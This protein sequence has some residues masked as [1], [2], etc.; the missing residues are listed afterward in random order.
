MKNINRENLIKI[1]L[2]RNALNKIDI[3]KRPFYESGYSYNMEMARKLTL[4]DTIKKIDNNNTI[5][6]DFII[7]NKLLFTIY[8]LSELYKD[9]R[10]VKKIF[11][12]LIETGLKSLKKENLLD[13]NYDINIILDNLNSLNEI[14]EEFTILKKAFSYYLSELTL[15]IGGSPSYNNGYSYLNP[16]LSGSNL[17]KKNYNF[18]E[19]FTIFNYSQIKEILDYINNSELT[20]HDFAENIVKITKHNKNEVFYN[21]YFE[22]LKRILKYNKE[23]FLKLVRFSN[24]ARVRNS[25]T[26]K[27]ALDIANEIIAARSGIINSKIIEP[28]MFSKFPREDYF[29]FNKELE[30]INTIGSRT[31]CCFRKGGAAQSLLKPAYYSPISGIIEGTFKNCTWFSFVWETVEYNKETNLFDV[32]LVFDNLEATRR[33]TLEEMNKIIDILKSLGKYKKIYLG[34]LRNDIAD[35]YLESIES[36]KK[37]KERSLVEFEKEFNKYSAY[38]DSR[39]MF[40]ILENESK[41]KTNITVKKLNLGDLHRAKYVEWKIWSEHSDDEFVKDVILGNSFI[42]QDNQSIYGYLITKK[43]WYD[44]TNKK[45]YFQSKI[46][47]ELKEK[48]KMLL[49]FDDFYIVRNNK[50]IKSLDKIFDEIKKYIEENNI[51]YY[52]CHCNE[53]SK[54]FTKRLKGI[55]KFIPDERFGSFIQGEN[56]ANGI[57][58]SINRKNNTKINKIEYDF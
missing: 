8:F 14:K 38:D 27:E 37:P 56:I 15:G 17:I 3:N 22:Y 48:C 54:N 30:E 41:N 29:W 49:Y 46:S 5:I 55:C 53:Y 58:T 42:I 35:E 24:Y 51:E 19:L 20:I 12:L 11:S 45:I 7:E 28:Y 21:E 26:L 6:N 4:Y 2:H 47:K 13:K 52:S 33:L 39:Y 18:R 23:N 50:I 32:S 36:T 44:E 34:Y 43:Y 25:S 10:K 9:N 57:T 31:Y 16:N 1:T 40:T